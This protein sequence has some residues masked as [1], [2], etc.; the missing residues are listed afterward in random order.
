[1]TNQELI[2]IL[3]QR[4]PVADADIY[5]SHIIDC[6]DTVVLQFFATKEDRDAFH[7]CA[8][9][10]WHW[11]RDGEVNDSV[12]VV[13]KETALVDL[14]PDYEDVLNMDRWAKIHWI[15]NVQKEDIGGGWSIGKT[16][17]DLDGMIRR[18]MA[19]E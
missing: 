5:V 11:L 1:M 9:I 19:T 18:L 10:P 16:D 7:K 12:T 4:D 2:N 6:G 13:T 8:K 14:N 15:K 3:Q 17:A